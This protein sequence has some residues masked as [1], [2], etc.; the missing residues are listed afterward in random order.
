MER[1]EI[2]E[3]C[4][5]ENAE[6]LFAELSPATSR[7]WR[8]QGQITSQNSWIFRGQANGLKGE[9]WKLQPSAHRPNAF[10]PFVQYVT[11]PLRELEPQD[12]RE[13]ELGFVLQFADIADRHGF[14]IPGDSP[15]LR[16]PRT[17]R[18]DLCKRDLFP[19]PELTAMTALAQHY[20]VPTRLLDWTRSPL[21]ATYFAAEP[22]AKRRELGDFSPDPQES[23]FSVF[24]LRSNIPYIC[25]GLDPEI[26][27]LTVPTASNANLHAQQGLFTLIQPLEADPSPLPLLDEVLRKHEG[28][29]RAQAERV[30]FPLMIEYRIPAIEARTTLLTLECM[31][32]TAASI[33]PGLHGVVQAMK[34]QRFFQYSPPRSRS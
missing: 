23:H 8:L 31:G 2:I 18:S 20:G 34:E 9:I 10:L 30:R 1:D 29:I 28:Q 3:V 21:I 12:L 15:A 17:T 24:A 7:L 22:V 32:V 16:D 25:K 14:P 26:H 4:E 13:A 33:Y 19:S 27:T 6:A 5:L 11:G